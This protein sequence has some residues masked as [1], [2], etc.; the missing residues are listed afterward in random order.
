MS[1]RSALIPLAILLTTACGQESPTEVGG[2]LLPGGAV[3]TYEVLLPSSQYLQYDT[4]F[5][6]FTATSTATYAIL[7]QHFADSLDAHSLAGLLLPTAI[8]VPDSGTLITDSAATFFSGHI[9]IRVD[10]AASGPREQV[11]VGVYR[12]AEDWDQK[13]TSWE[14]RVDS[15]GVHEPWAEPGGTPGKVVGTASL[16]EGADSLV[17][18]VD[19][20]TLAVWGDS[21]VANRGLMVV[22]AQAG[23]RIRT[24]DLS[25][26]VDAHPS[27]RTDTVVTVTVHP[28]RST[29]IYTPQLTGP[30]T[31]PRFGGNPGWRTLF[32]FRDGLDSL[33]IPCASG[34]VGCSVA[35]RDV[36]VSLAELV[37]QPT[38]PPAGF[39]PEQ[40]MIAA[41]VVMLYSPG[42]PLDRLPLGSAAATTGTTVTS[43][44]FTPPLSGAPLRV[45]IT[46]FVQA[47]S[48][49]STGVVRPPPYL[50]LIP[51]G[52]GNTFGIATFQPGPALRLVVT[53][54]EEIQ[55]R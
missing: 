55:I 54:A 30:T 28:T 41:P 43:D 18:P 9:I 33:R 3:N 47:L 53:V 22:A 24:T 11:Q 27:V 6:G 42:I 10:T 46:S 21:V 34:A 31:A 37:L 12:L 15:G 52:E 23:A 44:A 8:A 39:A 45:P 2:P 32:R 40:N 4:A 13:S 25:M 36:S 26:L 49:D 14:W 1:R 20:A 50:A 17:I 5:T 19:S 7:A 35:L 16:E 48:S 51:S 38:V 29:F